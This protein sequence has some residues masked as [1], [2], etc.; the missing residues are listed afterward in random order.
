M[1]RSSEFLGL[2]KLLNN[3]DYN[4]YSD[5]VLPTSPHG[6]SDHKDIYE[7]IF[8]V[9]DPGFNQ[10]GSYSV[11]EHGLLNVTIL[12]N[13]Q[14][15]PFNIVKI[16]LTALGGIY[17]LSLGYSSTTF[18]PAIVS[19]QVYTDVTFS[20]KMGGTTALQGM[21]SSPRKSSSFDKDIIDYL[22]KRIADMEASQDTEKSGCCYKCKLV[23]C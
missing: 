9:S 10:V 3:A 1:D 19:G 21:L 13:K 2:I 6:V 11:N 15:I 14:Q 8:T 20:P 16:S 23:A 18:P 7:L 12:G 17:Y 5:N 22:S 4:G